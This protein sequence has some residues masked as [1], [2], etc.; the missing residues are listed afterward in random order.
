MSVEIRLIAPT[1][2]FWVDLRL[3]RYGEHW[4]AVADISGDPEIG[5]G[6]SAHEAIAVAVASLGPRAVRELLADPALL[7]ISRRLRSTHR[8]D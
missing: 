1:L 8:P 4:L 3:R 5:L 7:A 6:A 2:D